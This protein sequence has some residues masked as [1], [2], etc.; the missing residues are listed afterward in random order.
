MP[1]TAETSATATSHSE[2]RTPVL[3]SGPRVV[4]VAAAPVG[5]DVGTVAVPGE[6]T[7]A[8]GP[9]GVPWAAGVEVPTAGG[10]PGPEGDDGP[11]GPDGPPGPCGALPAGR[12]D[13]SEAA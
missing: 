8:P 2:T 7:G 6:G 9:D 4:C 11:I 1:P 12:I 13:G 10:W 3:A 5:V